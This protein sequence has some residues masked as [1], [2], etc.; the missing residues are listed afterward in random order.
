MS[1]DIITPKYYIGELVYVGSVIY[2][3][4][5]TQQVGKVIS[6]TEYF[7]GDVEYGIEIELPTHKRLY[8][9]EM[10][11]IQ[12]KERDIVTIPTNKQDEDDEL[13]KRRF[14]IN[15]FKY[16]LGSW[17]CHKVDIDWKGII[18]ARTLDYCNTPKYK[19]RVPEGRI[20][21]EYEIMWE[22]QS[23]PSFTTYASAQ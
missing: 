12:L 15:V 13:V 5:A 7:N 9:G 8:A 3:T 10:T 16:R 11:V 23:D 20:V 18:F 21:D 17:V 14:N 19:V 6:F 1:V 22:R 4:P 2:K